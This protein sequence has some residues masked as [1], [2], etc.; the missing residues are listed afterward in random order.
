M[1]ITKLD[2]GREGDA[3]SLLAR[4]MDLDPVSVWLFP[5]P[6]GRA[7]ALPLVTRAFVDQAMATDRV[8]VDSSG[9]GVSAW[10]REDGTGHGAPWDEDPPEEFAPYADRL[11][12]MGELVSARHP[13]E[14]HLYLPMIGVLDRAR[15]RGV[16]SA[17]LRQR[18]DDADLPVYLEASSP[19]SRDLY[20]RHGFTPFG[21]PVHFPDGPPMFPMLRTPR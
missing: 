10:I 6:E 9:D 7:R 19:R 13:T 20:L 3:A 12:V 2:Q 18:L 5:D 16:G 8:L 21:D 14:P 17:M 15:G 11:T 1:E 4:A